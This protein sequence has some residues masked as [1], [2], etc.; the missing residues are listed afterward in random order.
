MF[1]KYSYPTDIS[2]LYTINVNKNIFQLL[3]IMF[4]FKKKIII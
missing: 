1:E 2:K 4:V 3:Y